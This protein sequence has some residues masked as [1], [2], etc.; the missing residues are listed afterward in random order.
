MANNEISAEDI[1]K[2]NPDLFSIPRWYSHSENPYFGTFP[3][4][5]ELVKFVGNK[6]NFSREFS[7]EPSKVCNG[8]LCFRPDNLTKKGEEN[9]SKLFFRTQADNR[10]WEHNAYLFFLKERTDDVIELINSIEGNKQEGLIGL[11]ILSWNLGVNVNGAE[12]YQSAWK[13]D[14]VA[15]FIKTKSPSIICLQE[16]PEIDSTLGKYNYFDRMRSWLESQNY[17]TQFALKGGMT[18]FLTAIKSNLKFVGDKS[19]SPANSF[20]YFKEGDGAYKYA[21]WLRSNVEINNKMYH[22]YNVHLPSI[23]S[24]DAIRIKNCETL[25]SETLKSLPDLS[26]SILAGDFNIEIEKEKKEPKSGAVYNEEGQ[27]WT[28]DKHLDYIF[29]KNEY[30]ENVEKLTPETYS[31]IDY[32]DNSYI[33]C[34]VIADIMIA[35]II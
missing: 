31:N 14:Q 5:G 18:Y 30:C 26:V 9:Y 12:N 15:T 22:I 8:Q 27:A 4:I 23:R 35:D 21:C 10:N 19:V 32:I 7:R 20:S 6:A 16:V 33:H 13:F 34:P 2:K 25:K 28:N 3:D 11:S 1:Y 17:L 29:F 24:D